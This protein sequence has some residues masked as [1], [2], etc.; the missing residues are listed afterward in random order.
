MN[1]NVV[2]FDMDGTLTEP[3]KK[4][5]PEILSSSLQEL[6]K[7]ADIGIVTGSDYDYLKGT[8]RAEFDGRVFT[9]TSDERAHGLFT[10]QYYTFYL[11]PVD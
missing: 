4:F 10:P 5:D 9:M 6:S 1:R 7:H 8:K 2:L 3:R 11:K